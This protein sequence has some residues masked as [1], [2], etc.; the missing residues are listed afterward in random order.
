[1]VCA[2]SQL[3]KEI[4][5]EA[6]VTWLDKFSRE[7]EPIPEL[8]AEIVGRLSQDPSLSVRSFIPDLTTLLGAQPVTFPSSNELVEPMSI[9]P[10]RSRHF[11]KPPLP[12]QTSSANVSSAA[13]V[14]G[15]NNSRSSEVEANGSETVVDRGY[16]GQASQSCDVDAT[17]SPRLSWLAKEGSDYGEEGSVT[18]VVP[19]VVVQSTTPMDIDV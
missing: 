15:A 7:S 11:S 13:D 18:S 4:Y 3:K 19:S 9:A 10:M 16:E 8:F 17:D 14:T 6:D 1:M 2:L 12:R 5:S